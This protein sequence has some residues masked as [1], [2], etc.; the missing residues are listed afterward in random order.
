MS[1]AQETANQLLRV[2]IGLTLL[3]GEKKT[4][5][6]QVE[7]LSDF[8]LKPNE[9]AKIVCRTGTYVNKELAGIRKLKKRKS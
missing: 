9:I 1:D 7:L 8:G 4:L 2:L 3:N 5:R 6:Q